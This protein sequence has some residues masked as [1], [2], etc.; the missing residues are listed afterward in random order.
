[1]EADLDWAHDSGSVGFAPLPVLLGV[2][3]VTSTEKSIESLATLRARAGYLASPHLLLYVT[4]GLAGGD[5]HPS[6]D[7]RDFGLNTPCGITTLICSRG[8]SS[9]WAFGYAVGGGLEYK[10][11]QGISLKGEYLFVD[12]GSRG[13]TTTDTGFLAA[14]GAPATFKA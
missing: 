8:T 3:I 1:V 13:V 6:L 14:L 5:T 7:V 2:P 9:G 4:G 10:L 11:S 12:L